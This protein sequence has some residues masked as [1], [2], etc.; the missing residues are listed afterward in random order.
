[1]VKWRI[2]SYLAMINVSN[3]T[4]NRI[5]FYRFY[6]LSVADRCRTGEAM[7]A[8]PLAEV[9]E[10]EPQAFGSAAAGGCVE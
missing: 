3:I 6:E 9:K 7:G 8:A 1:M 10:R 2:T 4:V 5:D